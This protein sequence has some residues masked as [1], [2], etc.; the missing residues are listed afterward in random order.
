VV[1]GPPHAKDPEA[2]TTIA[3]DPALADWPLV[4][5][6][7]NAQQAA[8][9]TTNFLWTTFTRFDPASDIHAASVELVQNHASFTQ[10][11]VIDSRMKA[12][13]PEE[14]FC[15]DSTHALVAKRWKEYFPGGGVE[16][17]DSARGH[18]D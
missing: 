6:V 16:M 10:P 18:L 12:S 14:L 11:I 1:Q 2:G 5:L 3:K 8:R 9:S 4:V 17:G 15:D 13:Y 7:D